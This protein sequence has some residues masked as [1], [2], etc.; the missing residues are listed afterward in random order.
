MRAEIELSGSQVVREVLYGKA[1]EDSGA[2]EVS[3]RSA[4]GNIVANG[5]FK[6]GA[7][8]GDYDHAPAAD[9]GRWTLRKD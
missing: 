9:H 2:W 7:F 5:I 8:E 1:A 4:N 3:L 6:N